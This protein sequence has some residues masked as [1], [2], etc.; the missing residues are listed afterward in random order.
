M[1]TLTLAF[2]VGCTTTQTANDSDGDGI[3]DLREAQFGTNP[4][5]VDTD[6][7]GLDDRVE[8][9]HFGTDPLD[10]DTDDDTYLDGDEYV[11]GRD[12]LDADDRIYTGYWPYNPDKDALGSPV[13]ESPYTVGSTMDRLVAKDQFRDWVDTYAFVGADPEYDWIIIDVC[14]TWCSPCHSLAEWLHSGEDPSGYYEGYDEI[15]ERVDRGKVLWIEALS[16]N[17]YGESPTAAELR[18]WYRAYPNPNI[19]VLDDPDGLFVDHV[20]GATGFWP[21]G[22]LVNPKTQKI[23]VVG[24]ID[25]VME[26]ALR[27][28]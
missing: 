6:R 4:F 22:I 15:R 24:S 2:L 5:A 1:R 11:E 10:P 12:P 14:T 25:E 13:G 27:R 20:V 3:T 16:Q 21:S 26:R 7:D 18:E 17:D 9:E 28:P 19:P 23:K 8:L